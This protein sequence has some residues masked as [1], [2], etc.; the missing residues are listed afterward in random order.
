MERGKLWY[1]IITLLRGHI[2]RAAGRIGKSMHAEGF[3]EGGWWLTEAWRTRKHWSVC[4]WGMQARQRCWKAELW[5]KLAWWRPHKSHLG[6]GH[7][8]WGEERSWLKLG[9]KNAKFCM[10]CQI[11]LNP[12][13]RTEHWIL[14][15]GVTC[16]DLNVL[17]WH[18]F[19]E[20][21]GRKHL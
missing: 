8:V 5:A 17:F 11:R 12:I 20:W 19:G 15:R 18:L 9:L 14:S 16:P 13:G 1:N 10:L 4:K 6:W 2:Q 21:M 7:R 3:Q